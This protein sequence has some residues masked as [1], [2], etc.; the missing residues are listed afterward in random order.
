[1]GIMEVHLGRAVA[2]YLHANR[3]LNVGPHGVGIPRTLETVCR[4]AILQLPAAGQTDRFAGFRD[5]GDELILAY[6]EYPLVG[7]SRLDL[8]YRLA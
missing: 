6:G 3:L 7:R 8:H 5:I 2:G 1:M 4:E